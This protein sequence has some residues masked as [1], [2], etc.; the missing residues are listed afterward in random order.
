MTTAI[1]RVD[2]FEQETSEGTKVVR[3]HLPVKGGL[4]AGETEAKGFY[5]GSIHAVISAGPRMIPQ[6]IRFLIP[7]VDSIEDAF[8]HFDEC[9]QA[10]AEEFQKNLE[11][12]RK[13]IMPASP[14]DLSAI[15]KLA[16]ESGGDKKI[17]IG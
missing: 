11:E 4:D 6:E 15:N 9:A 16:E 13:T 1:R 12:Q 14:A 10:A 5:E 17:V 2:T 7:E 3:A 8:A